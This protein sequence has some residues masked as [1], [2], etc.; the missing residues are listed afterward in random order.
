[1]TV[2]QWPNFSGR[3]SSLY[4]VLLFFYNQLLIF[5]ITCLFFSFFFFFYKSEEWVKVKLTRGSRPACFPFNSRV[6]R[7]LDADF[8]FLVADMR[9]I[10]IHVEK[11]N[12]FYQV[13]MNVV[14]SVSDW[15]SDVAESWLVDL[16]G[17]LSAS[18]QWSGRGVVGITTI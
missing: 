11:N 3:Q 1:M 8:I 13:C 10:S 14:W 9:G 15:D 12:V 18:E 5:T 17:D 4:Y 7:G 6:N 2:L 16:N